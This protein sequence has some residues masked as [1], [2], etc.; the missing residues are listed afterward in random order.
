M[1]TLECRRMMAG[2]VE[3]AESLTATTG[4]QI[5]W[6]TQ[7][8]DVR[9]KV[10]SESTGWVGIGFNDSP[11][12]PQSDVILLTGEG[13]V[14]DAFATRRG[15]PAPDSSQDITLIKSSQENGVTTVE[16][17]RAIDTGDALGDYPLNSAQYI[18]W[19]YQF[20]SDSF[21]AE[22]TDRG[23]SAT[24]FNLSMAG[25]CREITPTFPAVSISD[26][27]RSEGDSGTTNFTFAVTLSEAPPQAATITYSTKDGTAIAGSDYEATTGTLNFPVGSALT[28][29]VV[30]AV[31]GDT[32]FEP[33]ETF[34][35]ELSG[36]SNL[37]IADAEAIGTIQ[38][39]DSASLPA[40]SIGDVDIIEGDAGTTVAQTVVTLSAASDETVTVDYTT[41]DETAL[42]GEDY[43]AKTGTLTFAPGQ[44]SATI[45]V[46]INGD[47]TLEVDEIME[48]QL[49]NPV[50]ATI[51]HSV[52]DIVILN[53]DLAPKPTLS[54]AD[55]DIIEGDSGTTVAQT[56]V[57]LSAASNEAVTVDYTTAD[58]TAIAGEDY[59]A[60]TG[61]LIFA[62]G[63]T[64]ATIEVMINGD[65][66]LEVDEIMEV[67]LSN[68]VGA[69]IA[70]SV[71]DIVILNDEPLA[72]RPWH[73]VSNALDVSGDGVVV[74]LDALLVIN[75][76]NEADSTALAEPSGETAPPP[77]VDVNGDGFA[78]PIDALWVINYLNSNPVA[79]A[80]ASPI[81]ATTDNASAT[82]QIFSTSFNSVK[83]SVDLTLV[84]SAVQDRASTL[85][86]DKVMA[87]WV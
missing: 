64:S 46:V 47:T 27:S 50:R 75:W 32:D 53:D 34:S 22:H 21:M 15:D 85:A 77:Y 2:D 1:E 40:L 19:A 8:D 38:N 41:A 70:H 42:A 9:F 66:T 30:V 6:C 23:S 4:F 18:L 28:K 16:F 80:A 58:E 14:L 52:S 25:A 67:Q 81:A 62:P 3:Y 29:N 44:T 49:S 26:V 83:T 78:S 60:N 82:E 10:T 71:S 7:Q 13:N 51:A 39:D 24:P 37:T 43:V 72:G 87:A 5:Q 59:V 17:S 57:T 35:V 31:S 61:T 55:V 79:V 54:I 12:M 68:P 69:T 11:R 73:N 36:P 63:Q 86:K 74:P 33:T 84:A 65:T 20:S 45:E 56:V 48:V 76:L